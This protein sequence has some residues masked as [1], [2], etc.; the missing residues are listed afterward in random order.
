MALDVPALLY[1]VVLNV[2]NWFE[3]MLAYT[4]MV[5]WY[6]ACM[7]IVICVRFLLNPL[8]G[9]ASVYL[10]LRANAYSE[11]KHFQKSSNQKRL[12]SGSK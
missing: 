6:L 9:S 1:T 10:G 11:R 7:F 4:G 5:P 8:L 12:S 3:M 2:Q